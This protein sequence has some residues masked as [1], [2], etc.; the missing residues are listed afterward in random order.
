MAVYNPIIIA[1]NGD[2]AGSEKLTE[3]RQNSNLVICDELEGQLIELLKCRNPTL[4]FKRNREKYQQLLGDYLNGRPLENIGNW[5]YYPWRNTLVHTLPEDEFVEVRTN[6]NKYK[7]TGQDQENLSYKK[8]GIIGLSVGQAVAV[9]LAM[10]RVCGELRLADFDEIE[11]SNLNRIRSGIFN[12]GVN[13]AVA[14]AREISEIDPYLKIIV[15][16]EGITTSNIDDFFTSGGSLDLLVEECDGLDIKIIAR[17]KA[18]KLG[19]PVVMETNDRAMLDIERFDLEPE[20]PILHGLV[21]DLNVEI[22]QSLKTNEDKVPYMLRMIGID[23]TSIALRASMLEIEQSI[24]TWPQLASSVSLGAGIVC[25][26]VRRILIGKDVASGRFYHDYDNIQGPATDKPVPSA[27]SEPLKLSDMQ[28]IISRYGSKPDFV[29]DAALVRELVGLAHTA[30][31]GGNMQPWKWTYSGGVLYGFLDKSLADSFLDYNYLGSMVGFGAA[32]ENIIIGARNRG[33]DASYTYTFDDSDPL[34][35]RIT[36]AHNPSASTDELGDYITERGTNRMLG[37]LQ[38]IE[39]GHF[40]QIVQAGEEIEGAKITWITDQVQELG[41]VLSAVE[42]IRLMTDRGHSDFVNEIRWTVEEAETTRDGIDL[43]T[44]DLTETEKA[45]LY[46]SKQAAVVRQLRSWKLGTGFETIMKKAVENTER[47][48]FISMPSGS[49]ENYFE[50]GRAL[51]RAWLMATKLDVGFHPVS[52]S[53]FIFSRFVHEQSDEQLSPF[54]EELT[55]LRKRFIEILEVPEGRG[56][57]FLF[58]LFK[59]HDIQTRALRRDLSEHFF[60]DASE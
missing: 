28:A 54:K 9:A 18:K 40:D 41:K 35:V 49:R 37:D 52:P 33:I 8:V 25:D 30:P 53:T 14:I 15:F 48:G 16:E 6:R 12:L 43:R 29:P 26:T 5:V 39:P 19:I 34:A 2:P 55:S 20:R 38:P 31:S 4:N 60:V 7:I 44:I 56:E 13:K 22:L 46:V 1:A 11:L 47:I 3:I 36:F 45:G 27:S 23:N 24:T 32:T 10:E 57:I 51:Q 17:E 59:G 50:G 42:R 58:R 21:D